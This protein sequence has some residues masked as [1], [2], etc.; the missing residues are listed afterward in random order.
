MRRPGTQR[1][2]AIG[3]H[4]LSMSLGVEKRSEPVPSKPPGSY[5]RMR[6]AEGVWYVIVVSGRAIRMTSDALCTSVWKRDL[7]ALGVKGLA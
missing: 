2:P 7:A 5:P 1:Q 4:S 3:R 6:C